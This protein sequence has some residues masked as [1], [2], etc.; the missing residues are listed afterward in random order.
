MNTSGGRE[1][2]GA[3]VGVEELQQAF[4]AVAHGEIAHVGVESV[5]VHDV[6]GGVGGTRIFMHAEER[7]VECEGV[8]SLDAFREHVAAGARLA[9]Q[10]EVC[11]IHDRDVRVG[12]AHAVGEAARDGAV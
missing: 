11:G 8:E 12:V 3:D 2:G 5:E 9:E 6:D 7:D 4:G 10:D 1:R